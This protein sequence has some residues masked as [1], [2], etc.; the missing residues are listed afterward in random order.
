MSSKDATT[1]M[2]EQLLTPA[3]ADPVATEFQPMQAPSVRDTLQQIEEVL[4]EAPQRRRELRRI[5]VCGSRYCRQ[6][7]FERFEEHDW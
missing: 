6:G 5:C 1:Q 2:F 7:P 4:D 3:A